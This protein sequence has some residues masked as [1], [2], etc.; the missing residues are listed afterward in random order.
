MPL[1]LAV[2]DKYGGREDE[3]ASESS[4]DEPEDEVGELVTPS[5][6]AQIFR[7]I[8]MIKARDP[9]VYDKSKQF[10]SGA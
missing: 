7:T 10:F 3:D 1:L 5:V 9:A 8:S 6:D 2:K 4:D